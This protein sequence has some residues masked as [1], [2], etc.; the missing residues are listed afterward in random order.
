MNFLI[1]ELCDN[2]YSNTLREA[3][4]SFL[5]D[6][7]HPHDYSANIIKQ[8]LVACAVH[9]E[10]KKSLLFDFPDESVRTKNYLERYLKV[11]K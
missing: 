3:M 10:K 4:E 11:Y 6:V 2:D 5:R 8:Y 9:E 1:A 7:R